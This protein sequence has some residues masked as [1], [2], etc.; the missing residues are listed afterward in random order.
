MTDA[1]VTQT[2]QLSKQKLQTIL[3]TQQQS[4]I[5][6]AVIAT[7]FTHICSQILHYYIY[8]HLQSNITIM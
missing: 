5:V 4:G 1:Y 7:T 3:N 6:V 2:Y 8:T